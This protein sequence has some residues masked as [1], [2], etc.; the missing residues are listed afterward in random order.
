MNF[1]TGESE[2]VHAA[3]MFIVPMT[4]FSCVARGEAAI[5]FTVRRAS[6]TV[7]TSAA[8]TIR[9]M[10]PCWFETRTNSVRSSSIVGSAASTPMIAST[11]SN[12]SSACASRPPQ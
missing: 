4:L 6:M 10:R 3:R 1:R 11:C 12:P 7:S 8:R 5:E 9:W 2:P